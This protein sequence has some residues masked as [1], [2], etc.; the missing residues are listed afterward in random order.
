MVCTQCGHENPTTAKFCNECGALVDRRKGERRQGDRRKPN[1]RLMAQEGVASR[2]PS[3]LPS[4]TPGQENAQGR[5]PA[6]DAAEAFLRK[7][8]PFRGPEQMPVED[9]RESGAPAPPITTS[10][11][12]ARSS[13]PVSGPS[14]LG[15][16]DAGSGSGEYLLEE[17][18]HNGWRKWAVLLL[19]ILIGV[20]VYMQWKTNWRAQPASPP[21][22]QSAPPPPQPQGSAAPGSEAT[23]VPPAQQASQQPGSSP[24]QPPSGYESVAGPAQKSDAA[25]A[26]KSKS[27]EPAKEETKA[28]AAADEQA[29]AAE[30]Q[31][32]A[33][34]D[35]KRAPI[36]RNRK[37]PA[38]R[39]ADARDTRP[40][41]MLL[42]AQKYLYGQGVRKDCDQAMVYL[43]AANQRA[44]ASARSQMG[45]L[46]ATGYCVPLDRVR[47]YQWFTSALNV[48]PEN[49]SLQRERNNLWA[50]MSSS[51]RQQAVK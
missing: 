43:R 31:A 18:S 27:D 39:S 11:T 2:R 26:E 7:E 32:P 25:T 24:A 45:A 3:P 33:E 46:Y 19:L 47:A 22:S 13:T 44:S 4:L 30:E 48:E 50:Q 14:F 41:P 36:A 10:R 5:T 51:E 1:L 17:E 40:D 21:P 6:R 49:P 28:G 20:L 42:M 35:H 9:A 15:L 38:D 29:G 23:G 37:P 8:R 12:P 16:A 34:T